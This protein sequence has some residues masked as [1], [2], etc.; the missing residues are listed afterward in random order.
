MIRRLT[1]FSA[2]LLAS[3]L[4]VLS[5][6]VTREHLHVGFRWQPYAGRP[7]NSLHDINREIG[8]KT[9][10]ASFW[11]RYPETV[12]QEENA[13]F[14]KAATP[15]AVAIRHAV[16]LSAERGIKNELV[17]MHI[18]L[19]MNG[20]EKWED[21]KKRPKD[22]QQI[23]DL[24]LA[25]ARWFG[26]DVQYYGIYH[27]ANI[28]ALYE[29]SYK[30]LIHDFVLPATR[31]IRDY[32][33]ESG[34]RK[35]IST[36]G[37][38]P[39]LSCKKWYRV[40]VKNRELMSL[41][42]N[43]AFNLSDYGNGYGGG[44]LAG[45][46]SCWDQVDYMRS[47]LD[48]AGYYDKGIVA[49]ESW[50]C[51][52]GYRTSNDPEPT[53]DTLEATLK[54]FGE[55]LQ[56]G[57]GLLNLPW[58]DNDSEWTMGLTKRLDYNGALEKLGERTFPNA[59]GGAPILAR[60]VRVSGPE[61]KPQ[62][63]NDEKWYKEAK[64]RS[65]YSVPNDPNHPHYYIWRWYAQ[66]S[67]ASNECIR[68][69]CRDE[70]GNDIV[71]EGVEPDSVYSMSSYDR[72][73]ER[74][75]VLIVGQE[76]RDDS[77]KITIRIPARIQRGRY[78]HHD[79][80]FVGEGFDDSQK[81][82]VRWR[83]EDMIPPTGMSTNISTGVSPALPVMDGQLKAEIPAARRLTTVFFEKPGQQGRP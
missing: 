67:S 18:P 1:L 32:S 58:C 29:G 50:V 48:K 37:L 42:D 5:Y 74:F 66:L 81:Y 41:I 65:E 68:H 71:L 30:E 64:F 54:L 43:W 35:I 53:G 55:C 57:V 49:A 12:T 69:T 23:Y 61:D 70:K 77:T 9:S 7:K 45:V 59:H 79:D 75:T 38:S 22:P 44:L 72:T 39:S 21:I 34:Q 83:T 6:D 62:V 15:L 14:E 2:L 31:A 33:K 24:T 17:L 25:T 78:F 26:D 63:H 28:P 16:R 76:Q 80:K 19:W 4:N 73:A 60:K 11:F 56:R 82:V 52:D 20:G 8:K 46:K 10:Y 51:W 36:A 40:Q 47:R 3:A 27:E 13:D